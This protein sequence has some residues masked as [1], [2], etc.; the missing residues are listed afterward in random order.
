V[1]ARL[2][3]TQDDENEARPHI[4]MAPLVDIVLL[5]ICFYL[6]VMQSMQNR[7]DDRIELP[8]M[9]NNQT[10]DMAPAELVVN[11]TATGDIS[12]NGEAVDIAD[13]KKRLETERGRA[14]AIRQGL[15]VVVRADGRQRY[16]LLDAALSACR[17]AGLGV[18]TI[19]ATEGR[20]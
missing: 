5:L 15:S 16:G 17:D 20:R 1:S 18:V 12:L 9:V 14:E 7:T 10:T 8:Q 13:L 4:G 11:I 2:S 3:F 19:R 6:L